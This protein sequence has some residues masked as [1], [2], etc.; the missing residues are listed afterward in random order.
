MRQSVTIPPNLADEVRRVAKA[1][2]VTFSRAVVTLAERGVRAEREAK[3][4]L[5]RVYKRFLA[6][7]DPHRKDQAGK[8]LIRAIFGTD[9]IADDSIH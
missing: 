7:Q 9:A 1:Q 2:R 8:D 3:D 4:N 6:E 5:K